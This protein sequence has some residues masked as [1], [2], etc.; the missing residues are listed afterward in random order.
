MENPATN[1]KYKVHY[2][3]LHVRADGIRAMLAT[4]GADWE[5]NAITIPEWKAM[6][7]T[8]GFPNKQVPCLELEDGTKMGQSN[9]IIRFL[10][11]KL[12]YYP[13]DP[14]Q[15]YLV[16]QHMDDYNDIIIPLCKPAIKVYAA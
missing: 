6:K 1:P 4:A 12:G 15:A 14:M 16:D 9:A 11:H 3:P 13:S 8:C 10:G 2:F 5:D 7:H